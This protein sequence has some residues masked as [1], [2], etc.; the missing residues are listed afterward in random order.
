MFLST[1][2]LSKSTPNQSHLL[3]LRYLYWRRVIGIINSRPQISIGK[4]VHFEQST[5]CGESPADCRFK[6]PI[7]QKKNSNRYCPNLSFNSIR[8]CTHKCFDFQILLSN[9]KKVFN[10]PTLFVNC[11]N[12]ESCKGEIVSQEDECSILFFIKILNDSQLIGAFLSGIKPL[13]I[14]SR[15][16][17]HVRELSNI[18]VFIYCI[19]FQTS[20]KVCT[21]TTQV[22]RQIIIYIPLVKYRNTAGFMW[23]KLQHLTEKTTIFILSQVLLFGGLG[24]RHLKNNNLF[25]T[26]IFYL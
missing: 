21:S 4:Q 22:Y 13:Q 18:T 6:L 10:I 19:I 25:S 1:G 26:F 16:I 5:Q 3:G 15:V 7:L 8:G 9:F 14:N 23:K 17:N 11:C 20:H 24:F 12:S 2:M